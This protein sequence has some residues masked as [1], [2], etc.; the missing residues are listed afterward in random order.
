MWFG[1]AVLIRVQV[2]LNGCFGLVVGYLNPMSVRRV[3]G[4]LSLVLLQNNAEH[5]TRA[6]QKYAGFDVGL[7]ESTWVV[8]SGYLENM[9]LCRIHEKSPKHQTK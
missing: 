8:W 4:I 2:T 5:K 7:Q 9:F 1:F 3:P 6:N